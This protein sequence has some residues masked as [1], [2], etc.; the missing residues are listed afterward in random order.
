MGLGWSHW[1]GS[2]VWGQKI[3]VGMTVWVP[4]P[5]GRA[6]PRGPGESVREAGGPPLSSVVPEAPG[7]GVTMAT[8][9]V[10]QAAQAGD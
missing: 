5:S 6:S 2:T 7:A 8:I 3:A 9:C 1:D 4:S 10:S